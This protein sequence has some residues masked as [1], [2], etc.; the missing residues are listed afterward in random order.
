[1]MEH[2]VM[3][4]D[5]T[6]ALRPLTEGNIPN[7]MALAA[8]NVHEYI[9]MGVAPTAEVTYLSPLRSADQMPFVQLIHGELAGCTR[10]LEIRPVQ[11]SL[12]IG[13]TWLAPSFMRTGAN[14]TFKRLL[15]EH[16]F[17][18]MSMSWVEFKTDIRT[19]RSQAAIAALG[20]AREGVLRKDRY[21]LDGTARDTVVYSI[22]DDEWASVKARLT[23]IS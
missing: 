1:M 7:L 19:L 13:G 6:Y 4:S 23:Q 22:I 3:L 9:H 18:V 20:A 16:A 5:G 17:E 15:L 14:R 8:C 2:D 11:R 10:Y 12:E 21:R